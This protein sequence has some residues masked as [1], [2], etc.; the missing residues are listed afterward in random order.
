MDSGKIRLCGAHRSA[1]YGGAHAH[2]Q[3]GERVQRARYLRAKHLAEKSGSII[4]TLQRS[5]SS[6]LV[7]IG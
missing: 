2:V 4:M 1:A 5:A 3:R 7:A 6:S